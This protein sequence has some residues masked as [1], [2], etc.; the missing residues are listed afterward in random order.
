VRALALTRLC[1]GGGSL[2]VLALVYRNRMGDVCG[3]CSAK[4]R[5]PR[6]GNRTVEK[7]HAAYMKC[8][9]S[10]RDRLSMLDLFAW[11]AAAPSSCSFG[12]SFGSPRA[13]PSRGCLLRLVLLRPGLA[14]ICMEATPKLMRQILRYTPRVGMRMQVTC[15][16]TTFELY[17]SSGQSSPHSCGRDRYTGSKWVLPL[18]VAR[19]SA[20]AASF[21]HVRGPYCTHLSLY[22]WIHWILGVVASP[23]GQRGTLMSHSAIVA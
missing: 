7:P 4:S 3:C 14:L 2:V 21:C 11:S 10:M 9:L 13:A 16:G 8:W 18:R 19:S 12:I 20:I 1:L 6:E 22:R 23:P 5:A 17:I 15:L